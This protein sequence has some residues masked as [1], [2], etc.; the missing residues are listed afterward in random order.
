M[1]SV[2]KKTFVYKTV[3]DLEIQ[4]DIYLPPSTLPNKPYPVVIH[5][6]GGGLIAGDRNLQI[7]D[8][9]NE[10][11]QEN[12]IYISFDYRLGPEIKIYDLWADC[13]DH[14]KWIFTELPKL[15]SVE[16]DCTKIATIGESAGGYLA[17]L[18]GYKLLSPCPTVIVNFFGIAAIQSDFY[19]RPKLDLTPETR[20]SADVLKEI[21]PKPISQTLLFTPDM[22]F[23]TR[24]MLY[25]YYFQNGLFL[26]ELWGLNPELPEDR[27]KLSP[28]IPVKNITKE[29]PPTIV[30][31]GNKDP[32]VP[33]EDSVEFVE[34][35]KRNEVEHQ[36]VMADVEG[37][38]FF[39]RKGDEGYEKYI[40]PSFLWIKK[41]FSTRTV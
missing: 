13:Q 35:L 2:N 12:W 5:F 7:L 26:K 10:F 11:L 27:E 37:H 39:F 40:Y 20:V 14:W 34:G 8:L 16:L 18:S 38:G 1:E 23:T 29:F 31:H 22:K 19:N 25:A 24:F 15:I 21:L 9:H 30:L 3:D 17:L 32:L 36:F 28:W 33:I 4:S 6:H 41:H